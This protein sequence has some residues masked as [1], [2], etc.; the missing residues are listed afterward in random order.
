MQTRLQWAV[1]DH[2][3]NVGRKQAFVKTKWLTPDSPA[4]ETLQKVLSGQN[5][6]KDIKHLLKACKTAELEAFHG[7][8]LKYSFKETRI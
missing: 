5:L 2:N 1:L 6:V 4:H 8:L 7:M 3:N